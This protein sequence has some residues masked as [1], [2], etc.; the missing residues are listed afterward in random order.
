[1]ESP[2]GEERGITKHFLREIKYF[3]SSVGALKIPSARGVLR[4][5]PRHC[6]RNFLQEKAV[7]ATKALFQIGLLAKPWY[8]SE[9]KIYY[10][11]IGR[12]HHPSTG[13]RR[14]KNKWASSSDV[15]SHIGLQEE[16]HKHGQGK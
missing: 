1:L 14:Y 12:I 13:R 8:Y 9:Y 4:I 16:E 7:E 5:L 10:K 15:S 11:E 6:V 2:R 3:P